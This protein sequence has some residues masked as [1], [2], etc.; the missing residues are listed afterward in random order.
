MGDK[1]KRKSL[2]DM[3]EETKQFSGMREHNSL[4]GRE[5]H[6]NRDSGRSHE[7]SASGTYTAPKS[8]DNSGQPY[9]ESNEDNPVA[10]VNESFIKSGQNAPEGKDIG[11]GNRY[12]QHM[13]PGFDGMDRHKFKHSIVNDRSDSYSPRGQ[14]RSRSPIRDDRH[15]S[16]GSSDRRSVPDKSSQVCRDFSSGRC[17]RGSQCRFVHSE[18][19]SRADRD[20]VADDTAEIWINRA[21][22][23]H[24]SKH[25]YS[26]VPGSDLRDDVSDSHHGKDEQFQNKSRSAVPCRNLM[27]GKC[28]W[29]D[30]CRFSHH[31]ASNET[32]GEGNRYRKPLCKYFAAG[33]CDRDN[34]TFSHEDPKFNSLEGRRGVTDDRSLHD[35]NNN[36]NGLTGND[37]T[38][39]S[40]IVKPADLSESIMTIT[41]STGD[42]TNAKNDNR[43]GLG[44]ENENISSEIPEWR[45]DPVNQN[46]RSSPPGRSGSY[47]LHL[48]N[49]DGNLNVQG[50]KTLQGDQIF[51]MEA[52]QQQ[53]VSPVSHIQ[54][55]DNGVIENYTGN[56]FRSDVYDEV[57]DSRNTTHPIPFSGRHLNENG[58]NVFHGYSSISNATDGDHNMLWPKT[59]N[60]FSDDLN[61]PDTNLVARQK[62]VQITGMLETNASQLFS[63]LLTSEQF[64]QFTNSLVSIPGQ[65]VAPVTNPTVQSN[66]VI[67]SRGPIDP[68]ENERVANE[69][70]NYT[71]QNNQMQV[72]GS[73]PLSIVHME[74]DNSKVNHS[75]SPNLKQ[76]TACA[77]SKVDEGNRAIG[78]ES[79]GVQNIKH[80]E[81]TDGHKKAEESIANKDDKGMRLFKN[82]LIE[83]VK[84][85]LKPTWK[86]GRLNREAHKD[87]VKKVVDKVISTVQVDHIP[88]TQDKVEQYLSCSKPKI[89]KL[90]QAYVERCLKTDS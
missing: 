26:K 36:R 78:V 21:D 32:V 49:Q 39:I 82:S 17:K 50:Q 53:N 77:N 37:A 8:R 79:K 44:M 43:W 25:S 84:N 56:S 57:K 52:W 24:V 31:F 68:M 18:N 64:A 45:D 89:A 69:H 23:G 11:G 15:Q 59:A 22:R 70:E 76:E 46:K 74:P 28:R 87:I 71:E 75:E 41:N 35:S 16:Y 4:A 10:P 47:G 80:A 38:R 33:K 40:D 55:Q 13:S 42:T 27:K 86:E 6:S 65:Q 12:D 58:E 88:R 72:K 48:Q 7:F 20:I 2:W 61:G 19:S 83:S 67:D 66:P 85:I 81:T 14:T 51:S 9:W 62:A 90:V 29:G 3:G 5:H 30:T 63:N 73:S 54:Q 60:R 34:C 1:R